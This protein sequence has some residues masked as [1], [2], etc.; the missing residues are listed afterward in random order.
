LLLAAVYRGVGDEEAAGLE[1]ESAR[2]TFTR[3]GAGPDL[4]ELEGM[5]VPPGNASQ[6]GL[7]PR[8]VEVLRLI[9]DGLTNRAIASEL[10]ISERTVH[11][12]VTNILDKLGASSRTQAAARAISRGIVTNAPRSG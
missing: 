8:E 11:R 1:L 6:H 10:F 2:A 3:L 12:H 5:L 4:L 7:S 9:V